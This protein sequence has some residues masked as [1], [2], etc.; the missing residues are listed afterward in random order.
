M[1]T[2][3]LAKLLPGLPG[4]LLPTCEGPRLL[5][6]SPS[7]FPSLSGSD[8]QEDYQTD[9]FSLGLGASQAREGGSWQ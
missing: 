2:C 8:K 1:R 4:R 5:I 9:V 3:H 7:A 6:V